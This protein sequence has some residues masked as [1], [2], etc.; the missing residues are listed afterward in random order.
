MITLPA[1][2]TTLFA[3][4][5]PVGLPEG[6]ELVPVPVRVGLDGTRVLFE[7]GKPVKECECEVLDKEARGVGVGVGVMEGA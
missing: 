2:K 1:P 6:A 3:P 4:T 5:L 7:L